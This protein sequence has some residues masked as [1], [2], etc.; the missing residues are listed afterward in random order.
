MYKRQGFVATKSGR[1]DPKVLPSALSALKRLTHRGAKAYDG[2]SGDGSG[3]LVDIPR[4][5]FGDYLLK[6][7][8][9]KIPKNDTLAIASIFAKGINDKT[10]VDN[11]LGLTK[12]EKI[13]FLALRKVPVDE[14]V[15]GDLS[16]ESKPK[17][18]QLIFSSKIQDSSKL[19]RKLYLIRKKIEKK[20]SPRYKRFYICS[21]SSKTIVYKG[22]L[23]SDQLAKFCLLYTSP[24]PR[25]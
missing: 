15:L 3:I 11:F 10:I 19:E 20:L 16:K 18:L 22:L 25:D 9:L 5:F 17:I 6:K 21:F 1:P 2:N 14:N 13:R 12:K 7:H 4:K 24:S 8:L 23:S